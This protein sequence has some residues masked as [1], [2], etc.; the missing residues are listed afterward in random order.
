LLEASSKALPKLDNLNKL[1]IFRKRNDES[2]AT[3]LADM[4][5]LAKNVQNKKVQR[6]MRNYLLRSQMRQLIILID[7]FIL[8]GIFRRIYLRIIGP[9]RSKLRVLLRG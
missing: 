2:G 7:R 6:I 8:G 1:S 4:M 5:I 9:R 3:F